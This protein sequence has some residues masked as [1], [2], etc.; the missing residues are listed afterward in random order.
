MDRP[1]RPHNARRDGDELAVLPRQQEI[2]REQALQG[3]VQSRRGLKGYASSRMWVLF[4]APCPTPDGQTAQEL[5][6]KRLT[7]I[8]EEMRS[9]AR[10][11]GCT[12]HRAWH[13]SDGSA[14]YALAHWRTPEG[15][16]TFFERWQIGD[17]PGEVAIMLEGD[18]GL[19]PLGGDE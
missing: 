16:R 1:D 18:V 9:S 5:Y 17:E 19:V 14:F 4:R 10:D 15:A 12:F 8:S 3:I 13:A 2:V 6:E 7:W 11:L